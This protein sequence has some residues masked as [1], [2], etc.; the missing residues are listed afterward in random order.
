M[1]CS[2]LV[3]T[4]MNRSLLVLA[5]LVPVYGLTFACGGKSVGDEPSSSKGAQ[6]RGEAASTDEGGDD[7]AEAD[8]VYSG[9][10]GGS[11]G[12]G[13][14]TFSCMVAHDYTCSTKD[15]RVT[16]ECIAP[17]GGTWAD[18]TGSCTCGDLTFP[19]DCSS[20]CSG[21]PE[22]VYAQCGVPAPTQPSSSEGG[23]SGAPDAFGSSS[24]SSGS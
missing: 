12:G 17:T 22:S 19:I 23:S 16:C 18:A 21:I 14:P 8:C 9:I 6:I 24:S 15:L 11:S 7:G 3:R 1:V 10:G 13:G 20:A 2:L 4:I 5:C